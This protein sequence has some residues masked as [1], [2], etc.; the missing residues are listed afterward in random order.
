MTDKANERTG[1]RRA[2]KRELRLW[3]WV[4]GG[5]AFFA[6]WAALGASP[7]PAPSAAAATPDRPV[8]IVKKITRRVVIQARP[9]SAPVQYVTVPSS[10]SSSSSGSGAV[11]AGPS[12]GSSGSTAPPATSTGGS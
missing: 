1:R 10:G 2:S 4:A 6:P 7:K 9:S 5:L 3:A 11:A 8:V 12:N